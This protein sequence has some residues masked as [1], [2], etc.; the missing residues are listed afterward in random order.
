MYCIWTAFMYCVQHLI[1]GSDKKLLSIYHHLVL[2]F[3]CN[4]HRHSVLCKDYDFKHN[5]I[6][7]VLTFLFMRCIK[8]YSLLISYHL[9]FISLL[10]S[11]KLF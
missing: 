4:K 11:D 2:N 9:V 3:V 6:S 8:I 10:I 7:R 5:Y 1:C